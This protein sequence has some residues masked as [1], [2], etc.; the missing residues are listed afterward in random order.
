MKFLFYTDVRLQISKM[1]IK[2]WKYEMF[3]IA[4]KLTNTTVSNHQNPFIFSFAAKIQL[5]AKQQTNV[6]T[7]GFRSENFPPIFRR[8]TDGRT[9]FVENKSSSVTNEL[10]CSNSN[11]IRKENNKGPFRFSSFTRWRASALFT[12]SAEK[13]RRAFPNSLH[14]KCNFG[15]ENRRR[16][17]FAPEIVEIHR[18]T[19]T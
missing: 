16:S 4:W 8:R 15:N 18:T 14:S 13:F 2:N 3:R 7:R 12:F 10:R 1:Q 11:L 5:V 6:F 19:Q 17:L 9:S